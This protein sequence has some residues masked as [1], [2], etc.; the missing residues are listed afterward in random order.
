[1]AYALSVVATVIDIIPGVDAAPLPLLFGVRALAGL[2]FFRVVCVDD[3]LRKRFENILS[4]SSFLFFLFVAIGCALWFFAEVG[5]MLFASVDPRFSTVL[6]AVA[7]LFGTN[8]TPS[9]F[10]FFDS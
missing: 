1:M 8:K 6:S 4:V 7:H 3:R 10:S 2:R 5:V 9:A